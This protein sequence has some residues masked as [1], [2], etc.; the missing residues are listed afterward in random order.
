MET[1]KI[2]TAPGFIPQVVG[3]SHTHWENCGDLFTQG[4]TLFRDGIGLVF[5]SGINFDSVDFITQQ[6]VEDY[7]VSSYQFCEE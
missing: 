7:R 1:I 4:A 3:E 6:L 5:L 2:Y